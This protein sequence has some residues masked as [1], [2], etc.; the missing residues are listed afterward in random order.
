MLPFE[1]INHI[2]SYREAHP[3]AKIVAT[4]KDSLLDEFTSPNMSLKSLLN[5]KNMWKNRVYYN[6]LSGGKRKT[7]IFIYN[8][9]NDEWNI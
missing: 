5:H 6:L 8:V 7:G 2:L 1:I 4:F 9:K 3:V